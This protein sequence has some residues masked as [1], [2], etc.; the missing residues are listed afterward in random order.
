MGKII[1]GIL[2]GVK[3][4][5]GGVVGA[6]WKGVDYLRSYSIPANPNTAGQQAARGKLSF[7]GRIG[8]L[9]LAT[10][11]QPFWNPFF[12]KM[13]GY[14]GFSKTNIPRIAN[15][16]DYANLLVAD[17]QLEKPTISSCSYNTVADAVEISFSSTVQG[18]GLGSDEIC[19]VVID[20]AN[21]VSFFKDGGDLR[22]D[23]A[24]DVLVGDRVPANLHAYIFAKRGTGDDLEVSPSDY[25]VVV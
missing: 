15:D 9:L 13:S 4:K 17:G 10:V 14:N 23:G 12:S 25:S 6:N 16:S 22:E 11:I 7:T 1:N 19:I 21:N 5:V 18:N 8:K 3:G 24:I 2:G 20:S